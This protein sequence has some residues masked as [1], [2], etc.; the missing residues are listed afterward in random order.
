MYEILIEFHVFLI[1]L[2]RLLLE[3]FWLLLTA[4]FCINEAYFMRCFFDW[5]VFI[6]ICLTSILLTALFLL[7]FKRFVI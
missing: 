7:L 5:D 3:G 4:C 6:V 1:L 2:Y